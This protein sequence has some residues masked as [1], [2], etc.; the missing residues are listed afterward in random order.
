[1]NVA[2]LNFLSFLEK[3]R[4]VNN[5]DELIARVRDTFELIQDGIVFHSDAFA[6]RFCY[7]R[8][9]TF[10]NT[11]LSLSKLEK[12]DHIPFFVVLVVGCNVN[13]V[14]LANS[15]F[16]AK[17]SHSSQDLAMDKIRGSINGGDILKEY[18]GLP[19]IPENFEDL[20]AIHHGLTWE[21]NFARIVEATTQ[22]VPRLQRELLT[23]VDKQV[24][25]SAPERAE[26]F[27]Q[28][29]DYGALLQDL[30]ERCQAV[31]EAIIVAARIEN[32]NVRGRLI[33]ALIT[34]DEQ[35]RKKLLEELRNVENNY[36]YYEPRNEIG[37]YIRF[38]N[39]SKTY[40]DIKTKVL[41]LNSNPKAYNIDKFLRLHSQE[42]TVF[43][44][45]FVGI[46]EMGKI[47]I[48]LC[49][50]FH[51]RLL[52]S[53]ILQHHWA[54]R[55]TR[56]VAQFQGKALNALIAAEESPTLIALDEAKI[57]ISKLLER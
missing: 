37:D 36:P 12:Y 6:L 29:E 31:Y 57:F 44:F 27:L 23:E 2:C 25:Y 41:Y 20:F 13:R 49:S 50:V 32:I 9:G 33:E 45:Y 34:S 5:K 38:F 17:V 14:F 55:S 54:G 51:P 46:N 3:N 47:K 11:V 21:D 28:S 19:N 42:K 22:I 18:N 16:I 26:R 30:E 39:N 53:T 7:S 1:M 15:T 48:C 56:G 43:L 24:L 8:K 10:S 35:E 52:S 40:T 4:E